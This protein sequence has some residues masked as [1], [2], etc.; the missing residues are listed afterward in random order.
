MSE[1]FV[2]TE[3][4]GSNWVSLE[5][6]L[7]LEREFREF[8]NYVYEI[9]SVQCNDVGEAHAGIQ[10]E[11]ESIRKSGLTKRAADWLESLQKLASLAQP[12]NR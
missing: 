9:V 3:S 4:D 12:A 5:N 1:F 8:S 2:A 10:D 11:I 6:Y 7:A